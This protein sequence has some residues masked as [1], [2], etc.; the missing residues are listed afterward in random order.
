MIELKDVGGVFFLSVREEVLEKVTDISI[1]CWIF[2]K[3]LHKDKLNAYV[4]IEIQKTQF[5]KNVTHVLFLKRCYD[6]YNIEYK[7]SLF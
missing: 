4:S 6:F 2:A 7:L 1:F 5:R 3:L